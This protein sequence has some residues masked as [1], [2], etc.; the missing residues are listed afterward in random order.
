MKNGTL[1]RCK[2][3]KQFALAV[4]CVSWMAQVAIAQPS[5]L[6][7]PGIVDVT[8]Q[9]ASSGV[10]FAWVESNNA[11]VPEG[12]IPICSGVLIHERVLL[13]AGH[14]T[15]PAEGGIPP[16]IKLLVS[17]SPNAHD[18]SGWIPVV[19]Q[20]THPSMPPCPFPPGCDPTVTD[21]FE[22]GD[23][24]ISDLGLVFLDRPMRIEPARLAR[25]GTLEYSHL[26]G[27]RMVTVGYG[28]TAVLGPGE[29]PPYSSWDGLR[30]FRSSELDR[31]LN[32]RWA[33][34]KLPSSICFVD[35]GS[36]TFVVVPQ[37]SPPDHVTVTA[38]ASDGGIDCVSAD[39]RSRV[40]TVAVHDWIKK[41][42]KEQLG[43]DITVG[44]SDIRDRVGNSQK[45]QT[46]S[47]RFYR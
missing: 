28:F 32:K 23:P 17:F 44:D 26:A 34:W 46:N 12:L 41:T 40:D 9:Y 45:T 11:G 36:P 19:S 37:Q 22:A 29:P 21:A 16:F 25:P 30:R 13:T 31:V 6:A 2:N 15:G 24:E 5:Q 8:N 47:L 3:L 35:S 42:A 7:D 43:S 33:T 1:M 10:L 27:I 14:C 20:V 38:V 18:R 4:L 39:T